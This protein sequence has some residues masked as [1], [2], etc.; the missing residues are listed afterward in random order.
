M[1]WRKVGWSDSTSTCRAQDTS[2]GLQQLGIGDTADCSPVLRH[3]QV[4][5]QSAQQ[6]H[7][8]AVDTEP[9]LDHNSLSLR[10]RPLSGVATRGCREA[11]QRRYPQG[12]ITGVRNAHETGLQAERTEDFRAAWEEGRN[13]LRYG[14]RNMRRGL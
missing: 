5:L 9:G 1:S 14:H 8:Q 3:N 11:C 10:P 6:G 4:W 2:R 12:V 7:I 13:A